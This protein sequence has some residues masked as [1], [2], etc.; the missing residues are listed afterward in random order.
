MKN[1]YGKR[2]DLYGLWHLLEQINNECIENEEKGIYAIY[3]EISGPR[4]NQGCSESYTAV[5]NMSHINAI[6]KL[7]PIIHPDTIYRLV[8]PNTKEGWQIPFKLTYKGK[9][10]NIKKI[11]LSV[12]STHIGKDLISGPMGGK[13]KHISDAIG[14]AIFGIHDQF[15]YRI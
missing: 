11:I 4:P 9:E 5:Y 15:G 8:Y 13:Y 1:N 14:I 7:F 6:I 12:V 2:V 10:D 3:S